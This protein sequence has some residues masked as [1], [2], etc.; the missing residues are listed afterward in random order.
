MPEYTWFCNNCG[1]SFT[2]HFPA[3]EA[4]LIF[5]AGCDSVAQRKYQA[6]RVNWG[7]LRPSQGEYGR[8]FREMFANADE[9]REKYKER[10]HEHEIRQ[11]AAEQAERERV[12]GG[13]G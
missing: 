13:H 5:C 1:W 2:E 11:A 8:K 4:P 6:P 3:G 9:N 12:T 10:K 7:G